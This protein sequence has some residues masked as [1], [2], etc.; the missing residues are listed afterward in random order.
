MNGPKPSVA[1]RYR[2]TGDF[3]M[4]A[5]ELRLRQIEWRILTTL[6]GQRTI[7]GIAQSAGIPATEAIEML[8]R[9]EQLGLVETPRLAYEE[10]R[11]GVV[12]P[13]SG[14][15]EPP[16]LPEPGPPRVSFSLKRTLGPAPFAA[17]SPAD[18][19][20]TSDSPGAAPETDAGQGD[21]LEGDAKREP[22]AD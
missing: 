1:D 16:P 4:R 20:E 12:R 2:R 6:D 19:A 10:F 13:D 3:E 22:L 18:R 9:F 5:G 15:P 21:R 8:A 11:T 7:G 17:P 14:K